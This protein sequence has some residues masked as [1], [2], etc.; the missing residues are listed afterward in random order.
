MEQKIETKSFTYLML[1]LHIR[2]VN[3]QVC[4][5]QNCWD[6]KLEMVHYIH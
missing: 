1:Y 6:L 2:L 3:Y 5:T 4:K